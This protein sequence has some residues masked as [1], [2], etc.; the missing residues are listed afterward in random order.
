MIL[1]IFIFFYIINISKQEKLIINLE[2]E[3]KISVKNFSI[4][5]SLLF[6][7]YKKNL[8]PNSSYT[9]QIHRIGPQGI[10]FDIKFI[11]ND[12][13]NLKGEYNNNIRM[14][15]VSRLFFNTNEFNFPQSC[16]KNYNDD[17]F[18][19]SAQP[20]SKVYQFID[21]KEFRL[22]I[23][24]DFFYNIGG[25]SFR[26]FISTGFYKGLIIILIII[27]LVCIFFENKIKNY[28]I[29]SLDINI[30]KN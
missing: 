26:T 9:F 24:V 7:I 22:N 8:K 6:K 5:D 29:K 19:I 17:F 18:I 21:E 15:D 3:K 28:L 16:G 20:K 1:S 2:P 4:D 10:T 14:N 12:I 13:I 11:C 30:K 27:P 25:H 23:I